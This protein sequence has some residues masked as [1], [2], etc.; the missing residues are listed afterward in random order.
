MPIR[1]TQESQAHPHGEVW[2]K[3]VTRPS[4]IGLEPT[5]MWAANKNPKVLDL[6]RTGA[7]HVVFARVMVP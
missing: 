7:T 5:C 4:D 6:L 1:L 2:D 3:F